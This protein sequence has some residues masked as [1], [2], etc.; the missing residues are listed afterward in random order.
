MGVMS[1]AGV[2]A[3][4]AQRPQLA[5]LATLDVSDNFL[6]PADLRSLATLGIAIISR[7]QRQPYDDDPTRYVAVGE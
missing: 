4:V 7:G 2:A 5:H 3:L 1:A 6:T